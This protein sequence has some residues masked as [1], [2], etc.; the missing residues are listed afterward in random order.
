MTV[1]QLIDEL[2]KFDP[3]QIVFL[4][5][6]KENLL[7]PGS[8]YQCPFNADHVIIESLPTGYDLNQ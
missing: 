7:L 2:S 6:L 3:E 5:D 4:E 1:Q 8:I